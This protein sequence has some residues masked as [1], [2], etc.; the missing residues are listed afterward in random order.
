MPEKFNIKENGFDEIRKK[1]LYRTIPIGIIAAAGGLSI[2]LFNSNGQT[3][4][5]NT[6]PFVIP[7][8]IGALAF[9]LFKGLKRQKQIFNS[10][11]LTIDE[12]AV[13]REQD[14]TP[15]ISIPIGE[16]QQIVKSSKGTFVIKGN[17]PQDVIGIPSQ[18]ENPETLESI[19]SELSNIT[20]SDDKS[21]VQKYQWAFPLL[22]VVLMVVTYLS[23]NKI[24]VGITG[25]TLIIGLIYSLVTS[26][27][28]KHIDK[29][30]K[31]S[32][33]MVLIVLFSVIAITY[34]KL[35]T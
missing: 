23:T 2:S 28:S 22:T 29:K 7:I 9:G 35:T 12:S 30:T 14:L 3:T 31:R 18:I 20:T 4:D 33:W 11:T 10:F 15:I 32:M 19:L 34:F 13:T 16:I 26:Q 24:L 8:I 5:V 27:Q 6:L 21:F 17:S 1:V 25:T